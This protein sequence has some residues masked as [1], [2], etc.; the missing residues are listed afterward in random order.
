[1]I[2]L[3]VAHMRGI[4]RIRRARPSNAASLARWLVE[5]A[6]R[7]RPA[8][9]HVSAAGVQIW[10]AKIVVRMPCI[11]RQRSHDASGSGWAA[12]EEH[13]VS[14]QFHAYNHLYQAF[15]VPRPP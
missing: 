5:G 12:D 8:H 2:D 11:G 4:L 3:D 14:P 10:S 6:R 15:V 7:H 13:I 1:M 9:G